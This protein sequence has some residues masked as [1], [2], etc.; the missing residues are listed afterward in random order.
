V[1]AVITKSS[2]PVNKNTRKI[3]KGVP[4]GLAQRKLKLRKGTAV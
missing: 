1:A 2:A 3:L 4:V